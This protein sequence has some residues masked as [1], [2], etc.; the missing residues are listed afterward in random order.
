VAMDQKDRSDG[1]DGP[2]LTEYLAEACHP[3]WSLD[4]IWPGVE[5]LS[6]AALVLVEV[7]DLK[8]S[9]NLTS[10]VSIQIHV[11][12]CLIVQSLPD[13]EETRRVRSLFNFT[14]F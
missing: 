8:H 11:K 14:H 5:V 3:V 4:T 7:V 10:H 6:R 12:T 1:M 9:R 13:R 2:G